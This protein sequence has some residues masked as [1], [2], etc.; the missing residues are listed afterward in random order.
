MNESVPHSRTPMIDPARYGT[1]ASYIGS[2][3]GSPLRPELHDRR[4]ERR[5]RGMSGRVFPF[6]GVGRRESMRRA[7]RP[8]LQ[9]ITRLRSVRP[10]QSVGIRRR[11]VASGFRTTADPRPFR[12]R[13]GEVDADR[14]GELGPEPFEGQFDPTL[15]FDEA[16]HRSGIRPRQP[17]KYLGRKPVGVMR[18]GRGI[19][20]REPGGIGCRDAQTAAAVAPPTPSRSRRR[21]PKRTKPHVR[22]PDANTQ[23]RSRDQRGSIRVTFRHRRAPWPAASPV[24]VRAAG[25]PDAPG[26][27]FVR[28]PG[29]V[30]LLEWLDDDRAGR[31]VGC[32]LGST[33]VAHLLLC[34]SLT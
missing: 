14:A 10:V 24:W 8:L 19:P 13:P 4:G 6:E 30:R 33:D 5:R 22:T 23:D 16:D 11:T 18:I 9:S 32:R 28:V 29:L 26:I 31:S 21:G 34:G 27:R 1:S 3:T 25:G 7:C 2:S 12:L 20:C 15:R 17:A